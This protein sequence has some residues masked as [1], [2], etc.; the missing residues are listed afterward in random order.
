MIAVA[1]YVYRSVAEVVRSEAYELTVAAIYREVPGGRN[2]QT[3][4][5]FKFRASPTTS[6][7]I[8]YCSKDF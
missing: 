1:S 5:I 8:F 6:S 2:D 4:N 7:P 3:R